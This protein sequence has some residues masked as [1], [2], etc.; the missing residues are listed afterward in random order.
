MS[1]LLPITT[2]AA[3]REEVERWRAAH[4]TVALV[5]TMGHLHEGHLSL[6]RLARKV[7]DR[8]VVSIFVNP[9]QFGPNEDFARYPRTLDED[10]AK[11]LN[12]DAPDLLFVPASREIYPFGTDDA[13]RVTLPPLASELCGA[14]R[15]R[16]FDGVASVVCRLLHIVAP[17]VLL[18]GRKDYQ[19]LVLVAR[20]VKDLVMP[21]RIVSGRTV[22]EPDGVAMSSRNHYLTEE[23]RARAPALQHAL[24]AAQE[25]LERGAS[26]HA[27]VERQAIEA[28]TAA[29]LTPDYVEIR[30]AAEL[31]R[32]GP[33]DDAHN[34]IVLGAAWLGR[35]RLIDNTSR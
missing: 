14:A 20:M 28:L 10:R 30:R 34:L 3:V 27:A 17:D 29:G 7:A 33:N 26:D 12:E 2:T 8:V 6:V 35:A 15:P 13:V 24:R 19:Q 18:L 11:L 22:R 32:P 23:E 9:T 4:Q 5:P 21:V 25:A 1:G 31:A 16:H